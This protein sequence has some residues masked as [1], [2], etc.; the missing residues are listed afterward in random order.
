MN[1]KPLLKQLVK[2]FIYLGLFAFFL[3]HGITK[4]DNLIQAI[5][6][7]HT[8]GIILNVVILQMLALLGISCYLYFKHYGA[9]KEA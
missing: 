8:P 3:Y 4:T 7:E 6:H 2:S 1:L 9:K 5:Q